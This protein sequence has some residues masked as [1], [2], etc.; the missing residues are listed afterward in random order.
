MFGGWAVKAERILSS[1]SAF[2]ATFMICFLCGCSPTTEPP[3]EELRLT[4]FSGWG[5]SE[6]AKL[7]RNGQ[8]HFEIVDADD[9][10]NPERGLLPMS[11]ERFDAIV[12]QVQPYRTEAKAVS[13]I[14]VD[15]V[16]NAGCAPGEPRITDQGGLHIEWKTPQ[17]SFVTSVFFDCDPDRNTAQSSRLRRLFESLDVPDLRADGSG[18][19]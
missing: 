17:D 8:S 5:V 4:A 15:D 18:H 13:T 11:P 10:D 19:Q 12:R 2:V 7:R 16:V 3:L 1:W 6:T 9:P 14:T